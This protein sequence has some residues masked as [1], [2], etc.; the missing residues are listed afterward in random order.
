MN[1]AVIGAGPAGITA[2]YQLSKSGIKVD[3]YET[4]ESVGGMARTVEMWNHQVDIGPHRFFS[5]DARVN[6]LWLEVIGREYSMV[7]RLTRI[8][9]N[10]K[11]FPYPIKALET[12]KNLGLFEAAR[13][14]LS[15]GVKLLKP[16]KGEKRS[17]EDW[18]VDRFGT[19]LYEIFFKTYTEKLW[20]ISCKDLDS[21][22]AA[23]RIRGLSLFEVIKKA[24]NLGGNKHRTLVD[25]FA[26]PNGGSGVLYE[27]MAHKIRA[28]G[29]RIHLKTPIRRVLV[30]KKRA[31]GVE[32]M[33]GE[34]VYYDHVISTMPFTH[35][36]K[37]LP[38]VPAWVNDELSTL[39]FRN[40]ILVYLLVDGTDLFPDNWLYVHA[41]NLKMGRITNFRN[42]SPTL[43]GDN[44][45]TVL[46]L[47][48]WCQSED[49][50]WK[51]NDHELVAMAEDEINSTPLLNGRAILDGKV[52][53]VPNSYPIYRLGYKG[54]VKRV[55]DY[56]DGIENLTLI[57]R[58]GAFK[59]N[60]QDHSILMGML[61]A[62]KL[63]GQASHDLW[64]IN[65][66]YEYQEKST[67]TET[68]LSEAVAEAA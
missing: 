14:V 51:Q 57:G 59:Y 56:L 53:R 17:F 50:M 68:G 10:N 25:C 4:A 44:K 29:N 7:D 62:E 48:Y 43:C 41:K 35:L 5:T 58:Y 30:E 15:Y 64:E 38:E 21:D 31:V 55:A 9:Y 23:Q 67:I 65:S 2:A 36:V 3:V 12:L 13:C 46:S 28:T 27:K 52:I 49:P 8:F 45:T 11:F 66:D 1:I 20:G 34:K 24:L 39:H 22:F 54:S 37:G 26:Y 60:N 61:A 40:T 32:L 16:A 33:D 42:W 19:R 63:A 6:R 47:E 18:V